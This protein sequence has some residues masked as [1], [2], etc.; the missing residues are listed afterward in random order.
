MVD[1]L[2]SVGC[3]EINILDFIYA[4]I[5]YKQAILQTTPS[6][7]LFPLYLFLHSSQAYYS[8]F[9]NWMLF[10]IFIL[11]PPNVQIYLNHPQTQSYK[12]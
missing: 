5:H 2:L 9:P 6:C 11:S 12:T 7:F 3:W 10:F 1:C 4:L 8:L